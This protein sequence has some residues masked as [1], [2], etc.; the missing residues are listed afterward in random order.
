MRGRAVGLERID[1]DLGGRVQVIPWL[2]VERRHV[3]GRAFS[4]RLED[5]LPTAGGVSIEATPPAANPRKHCRRIVP[6]PICDLP[7]NKAEL[8][9]P[10]QRA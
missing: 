3:A 4:F 9:A 8:A 2:G 6:V 5:A 7:P 1:A 10:A